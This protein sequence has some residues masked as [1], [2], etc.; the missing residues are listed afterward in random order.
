MEY[1]RLVTIASAVVPGRRFTQ[2]VDSMFCLG[3]SA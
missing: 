2:A 1:Q 3:R